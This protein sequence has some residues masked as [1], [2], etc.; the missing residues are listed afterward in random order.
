MPLTSSATLVTSESW[1]A[2]TAASTS[3]IGHLLGPG[4]PAEGC[5]PG[6][7]PRLRAGHLHPDRAVGADPDTLRRDVHPDPPPEAAETHL[8]AAT[9]PLKGS[10]VLGVLD[11]PAESISYL[12]AWTRARWWD[13]PLSFWDDFTADGALTSGSPGA[14]PVGS[15]AVTQ[16]VPAGG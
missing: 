10:L 9:D 12:R 16:S 5:L 1:P 11:A 7:Q 15:I 4:Q 6:H 8:Q 3:G 2:S 13:G 14:S